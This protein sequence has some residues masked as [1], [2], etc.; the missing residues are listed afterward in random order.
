MPRTSNNIDYV[1]WK[2]PRTKTLKKPPLEPWVLPTF[3]PFRI[4]NYWDR[5]KPS[6]PPSLN[7]HD[8]LAIFKLFYTDEIM[9]KMVVWTNEYAAAHPIPQDEAPK[10]RPRKWFPT[11]R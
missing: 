9:D 3:T 10:G 6:V 8:P 11:S 4:N 7:Q 1:K 2:D 5:G